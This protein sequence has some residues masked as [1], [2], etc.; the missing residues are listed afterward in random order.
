M[1]RYKNIIITAAIVITALTVAWFYGSNNNVN[2]ENSTQFSLP[3]NAEEANNTDTTNENS[4]VSPGV[5]EYTIGED[6]SFT[7]YLTIRVDTLLGNMQMLNREKHELVPPDGIIF[8]KT[9]VTAYDGESV[10]NVLSREM[11]RHRI[12]M[13]SRTTPM[14]NAA[15]I[16]AINNIYAFDAGDLSGWM[17]RVNGEFPSFSSSQ[18]VLTPGDVIEWLYTLDL[19][20]DLEVDG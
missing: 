9:A 7:V 12:H 15:Y 19:G 3:Q 2:S 1:K 4:S 20:R 6:G 17:Y 18:Y 8:E 16:E 10:F 5:N 11:R 13:S 14:F